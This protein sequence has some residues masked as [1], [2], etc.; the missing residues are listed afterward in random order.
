MKPNALNLF[1]ECLQHPEPWIDRFYCHEELIISELI[2]LIN[3]GNHQHKR[4]D[5]FYVAFLDGVY[6][7]K[8]A[9]SKLSGK[10]EKQKQA[11]IQAMNT[12]QSYFVNTYGL[13]KLAC[14]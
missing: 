6:F 2:S 5:I 10:V 8:F 3:N 4:K 13:L 11:I 14:A 9:S 7:N 1:N 12:G